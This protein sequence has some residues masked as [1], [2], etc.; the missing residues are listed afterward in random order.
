[1]QQQSL[2][3]VSLLI[4]SEYEGD[5]ARVLM[6]RLGNPSEE[7]MRWM[8]YH[9]IGDYLRGECA[10]SGR[11]DAFMA[12]FSQRLKNEPVVLVGSKDS[13]QA[14]RHVPFE[15]PAESLQNSPLLLVAAV[16]GIVAVGLAT[17]SLSPN[18]RQDFSAL[19]APA[20]DVSPLPSAVAQ[21][22]LLVHEG[23]ARTISLQGLTPSTRGLVVGT[24]F[25]GEILK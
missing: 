11:C 19:S 25:R 2:L 6:G 24:S 9:L 18:S 14:G 3:E 15:A 8:L 10:N 4:D 22:Y 17:L 16:A 20:R 12:R 5:A 7:R 13:L 1:M 23:A 21:E